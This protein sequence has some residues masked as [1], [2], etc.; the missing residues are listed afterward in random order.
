LKP[1]LFLA[2]LA[3]LLFCSS[4]PAKLSAHP[5]I[6]EQVALV[7]QLI[8]KDSDNANHFLKRG[9]L[10]QAHRDWEAALGDYR[11]ASELNPSMQIAR[12]RLGET[13]L[14]AGRPGDARRA[15]DE[16]LKAN[17]DH[18]DALVLRGRVLHR[19]GETAAAVADYSNAIQQSARPQPDWY[20]ERSRTAAADGRN[21][22]LAIAGLDEGLAR[23][24]PLVTLQ[25]MAIDFELR[26]Q[27]YRAAL[28]RVDDI[29][30]RMPRQPQWLVKRAELQ[31]HLGQ[32]E[33]SRASYGAALAAIEALPASR[34]GTKS[35]LDLEQQAKHSLSALTNPIDEQHGAKE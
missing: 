21:L 28:T 31:A 9:R 16:F 22:D 18:A 5:A 13:L 30:S 8:E 12:L 6:E 14:E 1:T 27:G 33:E 26:R 35:V 29:L 32:F 2:S 10:H 24:G 4:F 25:A 20:L 17:A 7:N 3:L 19:L 11:R 34:R 15:L 23:L